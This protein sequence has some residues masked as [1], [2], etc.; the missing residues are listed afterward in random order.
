VFVGTRV[1]VQSPFD[2][3]E[4][5]DTLDEFLRQFPS[6]QRKQAIEA[7]EFARETFRGV[8]DED[9]AGSCVHFEMQGMATDKTIAVLKLTQLFSPEATGGLEI[10]W[11]HTR[12]SG[13]AGEHPRT[14][15]LVV[16]ERELHVWP[17]RSGELRWE[18]L[19]RLTV[20][21]KRS[22]APRTRRALVEGQMLTPRGTTRRAVLR[23]PPHVRGAPPAP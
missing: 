2:Y 21:P 4:A 10:L 23:E 22:N 7:L 11:S 14:E 15:F 13:D 5:G 9:F 18:P 20:Q 1:P 6:V 19:C 3:L 12:S 16:V 8:T 17:V